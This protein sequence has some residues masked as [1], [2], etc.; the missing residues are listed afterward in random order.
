DGTRSA[1]GFYPQDG[2]ML[3]DKNDLAGLLG[4]NG[5]LPGAVMIESMDMVTDP[6]T[7]YKSFRISEE[8]MQRPL[9]FIEQVSDQSE[10]GL[11]RYHLAS[12]CA[13]FARQA[14]REAGLK[15]FIPIAY[16]P[17]MYH[18]MRLFGK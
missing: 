13:T 14:L 3:G 10:E 9:K 11:Y 17:L 16:P 12:Q 2:F 18:F 1:Y 6:M 7:L 5:G 15:P 8:S 4:K